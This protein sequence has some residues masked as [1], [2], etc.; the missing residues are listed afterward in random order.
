MLS[1]DGKLPIRGTY[2]LWLLPFTVN[3]D[4]LF[5]LCERSGADSAGETA[6][7]AGSEAPARRAGGGRLRRLD[8]V[9]QRSSAGEHAPVVRVVLVDV[10]EEPFL[11]L[12]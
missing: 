7:A 6:V 3:K 11:A 5:Y 1:A 2:Y 10:S 8:V 12:A 4:E 9:G